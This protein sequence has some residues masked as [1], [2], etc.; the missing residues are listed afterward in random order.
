VDDN[1]DLL[2]AVVESNRGVREEVTDRGCKGTSAGREEEEERDLI[3]EEELL[4]C[5]RAFAG[6]EERE[7]FCVI[8][9]PPETDALV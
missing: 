9:I 4:V 8:F 3:T 5:V 2:R 6:N 1:T 7:V